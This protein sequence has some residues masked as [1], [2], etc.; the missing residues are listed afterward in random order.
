[1][2]YADDGDLAQKLERQ[3]LAKQPFSEES[4]LNIFVQVCLG[5][6]HC[7]DKKIMHRD[8]KPL[9]LFM[10]KSGGVKL[11]DFGI[12]RVMNQTKSLARTRVGTY[13]HMSPE[14]W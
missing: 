8:I 9:N 12:S 6:K 3:I 4:V 10:T 2:E 11:G 13:Y 14:V 7:H 1:M 5:L